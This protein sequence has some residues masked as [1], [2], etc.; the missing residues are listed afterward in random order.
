MKYLIRNIWIFSVIMSITACDKFLDVIPDDTP[1]LD[2]AF[3][4]RAA[5]EKF[6]FSCYS[7][8]P[9]PTNP[10]YYPAYLDS[11]DEFYPR[12]GESNTHTVSTPS[13]IIRRGEQN[14]ND[15]IQDY[16][17]GKNGGKS[18]FQ[19]LRTC[20]IFL[21]NAHAPKD[22]TETERKRWIAEVKF[23][24]AYY[25]F[26]LLQLY[27]PIPLIKDN[28][29]ISADP[30]DVLVFREPVDECIAYIEELIDEALPDLPEIITNNI[31]EDGRTTQPIALAVKAKAL[32]WGASPLFNG[33]PD[34]AGWVDSRGKQLISSTYSKEKWENAATALRY[35]IG[36]CHQSGHELY[37]YSKLTGSQ[38]NMH[39]SVVVLMSVRKAVTERWNKGIIWSSME[40]FGIKRNSDDNSKFLIPTYPDMSNFQRILYPAITDDRDPTSYCF[41]SF[42]MAELFYSKNGIPIDE[43]PDWDYAN[44]YKPK[45]AGNDHK[46]YIASGEKTA[47]LNFNR[48]PRFYANLGFDRGYFELEKTAVNYG[49]SFTPC[50]KLRGGSEAGS[51]KNETGYY[52]KKLVAFETANNQTTQT[53]SGY[54]YRFPLIRLADLYLLYAEALNE[55]YDTPN[56]E[57][58]EYIDKV[59]EVTGLKGVVD[60]WKNSRY[61][62]RPFDKDEMRKII[63]QERMIELAFE[64]QRFWDVRRWKRADEFWT[65]TPIGWNQQGKTV[66]EYYNLVNIGGVTRKFLFKDY[67]WP[68][69]I[70][71]LR[72]NK[73]LEQTYGW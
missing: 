5:M 55:M 58:Y 10:Y 66:E 51:N 48:E 64:G 45:Q 47:S 32:I 23:L 38:H 16:W 60:S 67:L 29:D 28:F 37:M 18:M 34:Y 30:E 71:D 44:R 57:V 33:N 14:S 39:D 68:I 61:P 69:R 11:N 8:L 2:H 59:R 21:E 36:V 12:G 24:K 53:Y 7:Y 73:N 19:A 15:P 27:G 40:S 54:D 25:H 6:L 46:F 43:D 26:F 22:I 72:V 50:L 49:A 20:N 1:T 63:Q 35:A 62:N 13:I 4:N 3:S 17:M 41:A 52:V 56:D 70:G 42:N 9:D 65:Q 31:Q